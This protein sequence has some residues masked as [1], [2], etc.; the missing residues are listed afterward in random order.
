V[1]SKKRLLIR[2][3]ALK[4]AVEGSELPEHVLDQIYSELNRVD[5]LFGPDVKTHSVLEFEGLGKEFWRS[6]DVDKYI[7]KERESWR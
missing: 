3:E 2:L 7:R 5:D 6:I 1:D 4:Q